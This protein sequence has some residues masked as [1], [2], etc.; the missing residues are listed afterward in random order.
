LK[1]YEIDRTCITNR[2]EDMRIVLVGKLKEKIP[3][4]TLENKWNDNDKIYVKIEDVV[5]SYGSG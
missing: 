1:E 3:L 4:G 2:N 5:E